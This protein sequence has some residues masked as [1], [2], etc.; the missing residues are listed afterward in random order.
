MGNTV[1]M[2]FSDALPVG[3]R[4][5]SYRVNLV[6]GRGG[7]GIV[8]QATHV[9]LKTVVAIKE[10][11]PTQLARRDKGLVRPSISEH[12]APFEDGLERFLSEARRLIELKGCPGIVEC[13]DF[14]REFGT[15]YMVMEYVDGISLAKLLKQREAAGHPFTEA[16]LRKV[17]FPLLDGLA[18]IH[19][20]GVYHRD[21]KPSNILMRHS[22]EQPVII[23]FGA[24]KQMSLGATKSLAPYTEGYAAPEQVGEGDIGPW[25]DVYGVG[26]AMWR[27]VAGGTLDTNSRNPVSAERRLFQLAQGRADPLRPAV[28]IGAGRFSTAILK[29]IDGCLH[30]PVENR[31]QDCRQVRL[32]L[33]PATFGEQSAQSKTEPQITVDEQLQ[34]SHE[35]RKNVKLKTIFA[36]ALLT[37]AIGLIVWAVAPG[38]QGNS[39]TGLPAQDEEVGVQPGLLS[40]VDDQ[41]PE[42]DNSSSTGVA[43][44]DPDNDRVTSTEAPGAIKGEQ[45][46]MDNSSSIGVAQI[47]PD[48]DRITS[49]EEPGAIKG[50]QPE[51]SNTADRRLALSEK[52]G[53]AI[54]SEDSQYSSWT[55][56]STED[57]VL[58]VE[59]KPTNIVEYSGSEVWH[60]GGSRVRFSYRDRASRVVSWR[61]Q[62]GDLQIEMKPAPGTRKVTSWTEGST[63]DEVLLVQGTPTGIDKL[64][65]IEVWHY[66]GSSVSF[67]NT[68]NRVVKWK[69]GSGDLQ[70]E[71]IEMKP[72]V[73][74]RIV[75]SWT[76]GSTKDEVMQLQGTPT[77][78]VKHSQIEVWYYG[79]SSVTF[80]ISSNRVVG[81]SNQSGDLQ[82][83][84]KPAAG[85]RKVKSWTRRSTK[86]QVLLVQG[87][88]TGLSLYNSGEFER[89]E[90]GSSYV[91]FDNSSSRV[92]GWSDSSDNLL[93][94]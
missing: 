63:K 39:P 51:T 18:R 72:S 40:L 55:L 86:D 79:S 77:G 10:Y 92:I 50:E 93:V 7:F 69:N 84:M 60:Y 66:G 11:Y 2:E 33:I 94:R 20:A 5:R 87:T 1:A 73:S 74:S 9:D 47:D 53:S 38:R 46:E 30:I 71:Q 80:S 32:S 25:T 59:G 83:E 65:Q 76:A 85:T 26:A 41:Q 23:D 28:E 8:Y 81:W 43:E 24:A 42:M 22:D 89:W 49:T 16:D 70:I 88:P 54:A 67:D 64:S 17:I 13:R 4:I 48:N 52:L 15:S 27:M 45:P 90:Y 75:T 68:S 14:F 35:E 34:A 78:V 57:E 82:V 56:G 91:I 61:N 3:T 37:S 21:I 44:I 31:M 12:Q 62:S 6:L 19:A 58:Q 36:V 29:T